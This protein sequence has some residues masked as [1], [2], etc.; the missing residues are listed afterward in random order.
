MLLGGVEKILEN[1]TRIRG[2]VVL[3]LL[4]LTCS[5]W[6]HCALASYGTVYCNRSCLW[7][8]DSGRAV[9]EPYYSQR[10]SSVCV[11]LSAFFSFSCCYTNVLLLIMMEC[12]Q[13]YIQ[14]SQSWNSSFI[15]Q[16]LKSS[17]IGHWCWESP[18]FCQ[19]WSWKT[20]S[21]IWYFCD[22][23]SMKLKLFIVE[24]GVV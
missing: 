6:L 5:F 4:L 8:C 2:S 18:E 10:A 3:S 13:S 14:G 9:S 12:P 17:A 20:K 16:A 11:S 24:N 21:F 1:G 23:T 7:V 19:L 22:V 15:F